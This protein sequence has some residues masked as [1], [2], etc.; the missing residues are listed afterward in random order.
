[1]HENVVQKLNNCC[2][3]PNIFLLLFFIPRSQCVSSLTLASNCFFCYM[4]T[5]S[6]MLNSRHKMKIRFTNIFNTKQKQ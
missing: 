4:L 6:S 1:M 3:L 5:V 2:I